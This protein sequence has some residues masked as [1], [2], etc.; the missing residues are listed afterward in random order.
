MSARLSQLK[1]FEI[2]KFIIIG[3]SEYHNFRTIMFKQLKINIIHNHKIND[4]ITLL[5]LSK[6]NSAILSHLKNKIEHRLP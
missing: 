4:F 3:P 6:L 2:H 5:K 1:I